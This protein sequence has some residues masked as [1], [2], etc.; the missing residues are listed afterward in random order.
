MTNCV[1]PIG[2]EDD[3]EATEGAWCSLAIQPKPTRSS[4]KLLIT[5]NFRMRES[6]PLAAARGSVGTGGG[7]ALSCGGVPHAGHA[8]AYELICLLHCEHGIKAIEAYGA[9]V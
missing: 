1:Q 8:V 5:A 3:D 4:T 6:F 7:S 9:C 2:G